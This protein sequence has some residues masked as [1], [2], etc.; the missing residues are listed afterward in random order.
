M[1]YLKDRCQTLERK[2]MKNNLIIFE[3]KPV[4][5]NF[6]KDTLVTINYMIQVEI[7]ECDLNNIYLIGKSVSRPIVLDL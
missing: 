3:L 1:N 7:V 6:T 2:K 4:L 5:D